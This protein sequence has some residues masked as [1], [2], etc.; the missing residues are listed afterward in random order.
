MQEDTASPNADSPFRQGSNSHLE[1]EA[2]TFG[3]YP[4]GRK[5]M[6]NVRWSPR[7]NEI[8]DTGDGTWIALI[9]LKNTSQRLNIMYCTERLW[10]ISR[11]V[12]YTYLT[13]NSISLVASD[14]CS[15]SQLSRQRLLPI[16]VCKLIFITFKLVSGF[17]KSL[18]FREG[19]LFA[20]SAVPGHHLPVTRWVN[21]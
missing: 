16:K 7:I 14:A 11:R 8:S 3:E 6:R 5:V 17:V 18:F 10:R 9:L 4:V 15:F 1:A 21:Y 12:W 19:F 2:H 13:K 20:P